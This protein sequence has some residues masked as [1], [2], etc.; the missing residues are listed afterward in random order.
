M[1][2][3]FPTQ[4]TPTESTTI[5]VFLHHNR[6]SVSFEIG[7]YFSLFFSASRSDIHRLLQVTY[8]LHRLKYSYYL[9]AIH[10]MIADV[11]T[12]ST[13]TVGLPALVRRLSKVTNNCLT[14]LNRL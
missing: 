8:I 7:C 12:L 1:T 3:A 9:E 10:F 4:Q 14:P 13:S 5:T 11:I 2:F 6:L